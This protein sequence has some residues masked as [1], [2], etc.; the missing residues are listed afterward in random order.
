MVSR[1]IFKSKPI[2]N[3]ET[4][5]LFRIKCEFHAAFSLEPFT[6]YIYMHTMQDSPDNPT[7]TPLVV[8]PRV[9]PAR[10][11]TQRSLFH[12]GVN[13]AVLPGQPSFPQQTITVAP[14]VLQQQRERAEKRQ[15]EALLSPL[16]PQARQKGRT[17]SAVR[18]NGAGGAI[19]VSKHAVDIRSSFFAAL[20][21]QQPAIKGAWET[22]M[23]R[24][25]MRRLKMQGYRS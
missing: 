17:P 14:E 16:G 1:N 23:R 21:D 20:L 22:L 9:V 5:T 18:A 24:P 8:T 7:G 15:R 3:D 10:N 11:L 2:P 6:A 25:L 13:K 19:P 4:R 12:F